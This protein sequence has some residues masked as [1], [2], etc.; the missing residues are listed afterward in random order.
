MIKD[1]KYSQRK[2]KRFKVLLDDNEIYHFGLKNGQTYIDH[3]DIKNVIIILID[4]WQIIQKI[5]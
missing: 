1:I 5:N 2:D 4:I 3:N